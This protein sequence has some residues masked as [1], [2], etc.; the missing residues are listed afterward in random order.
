MGEPVSCERQ[1]PGPHGAVWPPRQS[2]RG[3]GPTGL[4]DLT[5]S[6]LL[7]HPLVKLDSLLVFFLR[8]FVGPVTHSNTSI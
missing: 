2:S 5:S 7:A 1:E 4:A 6:A 8:Y 3:P